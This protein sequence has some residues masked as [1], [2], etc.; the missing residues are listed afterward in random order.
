MAKSKL[1]SINDVWD[2]RRVS[3]YLGPM[4]VDLEDS[5]MKT[6]TGPARDVLTEANILVMQALALL[7]AFDGRCVKEHYQRTPEDWAAEL[8]KDGGH[9]A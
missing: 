3:K 9:D 7:H 8:P 4:L 1:L 6:P 2:A 5:I